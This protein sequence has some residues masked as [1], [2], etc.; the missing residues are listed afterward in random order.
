VIG[1]ALAATASWT[2]FL[3]YEFIRLVE[4]VIW[5]SRR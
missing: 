5:T 2:I 1:L 4:F 3:G